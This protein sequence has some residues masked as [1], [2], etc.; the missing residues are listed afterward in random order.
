MNKIIC[1]LEEWDS[2]LDYYR[3]NGSS[4]T[5]YIK[6]L[7]KMSRPLMW[8]DWNVLSEQGEMFDKGIFVNIITPH[9]SNDI[10]Y[11]EYQNIKDNKHLYIINIYNDGYFQDNYD[12]G[13]S[14]ISEKFITDIRE[15]RSK[16]VLFF[17]FEGY[18]GSFGNTDFEVIEKWRLDAGLPENS[19]VYVNGNLMSNQ[20]VNSKGYGFQ[21]RGVHNFEPWN[22]YYETQVVDFKPVDEKHLFLSY[23]RQPRVHRIRF[24]IDLLKQQLFD[25]GLFSLNSFSYD[26]DSDTP[27]EHVDFLKNNSP[28]IIDERYDLNYNLAVNITKEDYEKTFVSVVTETLTIPNTLF[29]SEKM[30]KP[31]MVG[32]PFLL[33]GNQHSLRYLKDLG[34]KTFD[35]WFN[36]DYD[37]SFDSDTR[38]RMITNELKR[39]SNKSI[40]ELQTMRLEMKEVCEFNQKR[41]KELYQ[42]NYDNGDVSTTISNILKETWETLN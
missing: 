23:N 28:F 2:I 22:K 36:E 17:V 15:G 26:F 10:Q 24:A 19:V 42:Q 39:L 5:W 1:S 37:S 9:Y 7:K 35:K 34:Y 27:Q 8:G 11:V 25:K 4:K 3:P 33:L 13:F 41:Y 18:S 12:I 20:I 40:D 21:A 6:E 38:S 30:W 14:T 29:F 16:I 31:I 32:H